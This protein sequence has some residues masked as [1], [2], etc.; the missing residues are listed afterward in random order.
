MMQTLKRRSNRWASAHLSYSNTVVSIALFKKFLHFSQLIDITGK[1]QDESMI[2]L[3]DCNGDVNRAI[4]V[5]LEGNPDT[6]SIHFV[7][8]R[9]GS[10]EI[11][12][13]LLYPVIK[14]VSHNGLEIFHLK[15]Y[16]RKRVSQSYK[17][18]NLTGF[19]TLHEDNCFSRKLESWVNAIVHPLGLPLIHAALLCSPKSTDTLKI[20]FLQLTKKIET[21]NQIL[22]PSQ[23]KVKCSCCMLHH[24][25]PI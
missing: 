25:L 18:W 3:H 11:F 9:A 22:K 10:R 7:F 15:H 14:I 24:A 16:S 5:L 19:Y 23:I 2:A 1:D 6:V 8:L 12:A 13:I 17:C 4:N 21:D 20:K